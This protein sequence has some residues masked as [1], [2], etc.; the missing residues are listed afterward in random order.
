MKIQRGRADDVIVRRRVMNDFALNRCKSCGEIGVPD[1][2][3]AV[4]YDEIFTS[5]ML[6]FPVLCSD[7][8]ESDNG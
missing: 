4:S 6:T 5:T 1:D 7:C 8:N 2:Q 3:V